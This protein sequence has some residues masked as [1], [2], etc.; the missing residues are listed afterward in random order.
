MTKPRGGQFV[1][2]AQALHGNPFDGHTLGPAVADLENNT[3]IEVKRIHV[4]KGYRDTRTTRSSYCVRG[5]PSYL[6]RTEGGT[7]I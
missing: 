3:G 4:D 1:L 2:R 6:L 7:R 5:K